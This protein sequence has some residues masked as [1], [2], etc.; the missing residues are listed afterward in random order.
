MRR[1]ARGLTLMELVVAT[2]IFA[3]VAVMAAQ[4]LG[5]GL[6]QRRGIDRAAAEAAALART[7]A[8][9]RQ[10]LEAAVDLPHLPAAGPRGAPLEA[11]PGGGFALSRAG[12]DGGL[13]R[14]TW[15]IDPDRDALV[16]AAAPLIGG[17]MPGPGEVLLPGAR[18]LALAARGAAPAGALPPGFEVRIATRDRGTL[19]VVVAR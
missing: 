18:S 1:G 9:L 14:V 6:I 16:R 17:P 3:L 7:L 8:L 19:R 10:D 12:A 13:A 11:L 2:A 4:A 5:T 15:R